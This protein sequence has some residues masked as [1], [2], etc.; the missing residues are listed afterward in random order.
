MCEGDYYKRALACKPCPS[1]PWVIVQLSLLGVAVLVLII[2]LIWSG[3]RRKNS[4]NSGKRPRVDIL[5]A[6]LKIV[7]GFYQVTSGIIEGFAYVEWPSSLAD[8]GDY[9]EL[10]QLNI[11]SFVPLHCLFP[12]WKQDAISKMYLMLGS[13]ASMILFAFISFWIRK[14]FLLWSINKEQSSK[15]RIK[16]ST[17]KEFLY[18]NVFL[19]LF[20]TYPSTCSAIL[21]ILPSGCHK[22]CTE[23]SSTSYLKADYSIECEGDKYNFAKLFAYAASSYIVVLPGLAFWALW[24]RR[25]QQLSRLR[26]LRDGKQ[27]KENNPVDPEFG[28]HGDPEV[29]EENNEDTCDDDKEDEDNARNDQLNSESELLSGMSFLYE[30]YNEDAWYWELVEVIRKLVLTCGII[31]IGRESRTYVGLASLCSGLFA[32]AFAFRK[33]IRDDFEDKL[34]LTSLLVIF[35][36]LGIGVILKISTESVPSDVD[37]YLDCLL[38]NILVVGVNVLVILLVV[39]RYLAVL[40]HNIVLWRQNPQCSASCC[41][42]MFLSL[43]RLGIGV[44]SAAS[45]VRKTNLRVNLDLGG[46]RMPSMRTAVDN[47]IIGFEMEEADDDTSKKDKKKKEKRKENK[48]KKE[49]K[50]Q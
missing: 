33:P 23:S 45:D 24:R 26:K 46:V 17:T 40:I 16:L 3:R 47:D 8:I 21:R 38:V 14:L 18:R 15:R 25:R 35:L 34:Q 30:N 36:N 22:L 29:A 9:A 49:Q 2:I 6:R 41:I 7:I 50:E 13:N 42:T 20:I 19:F 32:V 44:K 28:K 1:G 10:I 37:K 27:K 48:R 12:S 39:G 43:G 4:D 11:L 31:L 5:L